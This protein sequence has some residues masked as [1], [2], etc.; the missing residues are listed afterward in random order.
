MQKS[1]RIFHFDNQYWGLLNLRQTEENLDIREILFILKKHIK[2]LLIVS[3]VFAIAG[4]AVSQYLITPQYQSDATMIVNPSRTN[5][6]TITYDQ[7]SAAQQLVSTYAVILKSDPVMKQVIKNLKLPISPDELAGE[8][9][10]SGVNETEVLDISVTYPNAHTAAGIANQ[11]T[12]VAPEFIIR[13]V[14]AGSVE[15]ISK[16]KVNPVPV[17]PNTKQNTLI[18]LLA[19][20]VLSILL[21][22]AIEMFNSRLETCEDIQKNLGLTVLGIIPTVGGKKNSEIGYGA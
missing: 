1:K 14:K 2:M 22:F 15:V 19:G 11:I 21:S 4:Y 9:S 18:A 6:A 20:L 7:I 3:I 10:V 5:A 17:S 16:A 8:V 12:K 13:T